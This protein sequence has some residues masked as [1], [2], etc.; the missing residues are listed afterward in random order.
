VRI[1]LPGSGRIFAATVSANRATVTPDDV[2]Q[3]VCYAVRARIATNTV[4][5]YVISTDPHDPVFYST[6]YVRD[7][8]ISWLP[9]QVA[10]AEPTA[11][12]A[13]NNNTCLTCS[14]FFG[15]HDASGVPNSV[16]VPTWVVA[17]ECINCYAASAPA[18]GS[19]ALTCAAVDG[20]GASSSSSSSSSGAA[21]IAIAVVVIVLIAAVVA[22]V[23][24]R[25]RKGLPLNPL[26]KTY[27]K[28]ATFRARVNRPKPL[29]NESLFSQ[30]AND[31]HVYTADTYQNPMFTTPAAAVGPTAVVPS[32]P[33]RKPPAPVVVN[34]VMTSPASTV[35]ES[36]S[37]AAIVPTR[38]PPPPSRP[39]P[40]GA[41]AQDSAAVAP[42]PKPTPRP[43]P[44]TVAS[45]AA[46]AAA[47]AVE[48]SQSHTIVDD[49]P[50]Q[51]DA[52]VAAGGAVYY[53]DKTTQRTQWDSPLPPGWE[54]MVNGDT[55][56]FSEAATG[57]TQWHFP[58]ETNI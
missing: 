10:S 30:V 37:T 26:A 14:S 19:D 27:G 1:H 39:A 38:R 29:S 55:V 56:Y 49:A 15:N 3:M 33:K 53:F 50:A 57:R 7:R 36:T 23:V 5:E 2:D 41:P 45:T 21:A 54:A 9:P 13:F 48:Q 11:H 25:R 46:A 42:K 17:N 43:K 32:V 4:P 58:Q 6:C 16:S 20:G 34:S 22:V 18:V 12:F 31:D 40:G 35:T 24:Y 8:K 52:L 47:E 51:W 44:R 28:P